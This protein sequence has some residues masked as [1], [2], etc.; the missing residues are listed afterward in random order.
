MESLILEIRGKAPLLPKPAR[1]GESSRQLQ[2]HPLRKFHRAKSTTE[3]ED[4]T[5]KREEV[6][7]HLNQVCPKSPKVN[8]KEKGKCLFPPFTL[9]LSLPPGTR[10]DNPSKLSVSMDC[11]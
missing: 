11:H 3:E 5:V 9:V 8:P 6:R 1:A 2:K 10:N 7:W 4:E